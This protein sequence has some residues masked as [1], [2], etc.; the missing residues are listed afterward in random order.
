MSACGL[1]CESRLDALQRIFEHEMVHL[2]ERLC[3]GDSD[4][5]APRF[6]GIAARLFLHRAHTH[7]LITRRERAAESG[8][9]V[10]SRVSFTFEGRELTGRV[11]RVTQR[12]TVLVEDAAGEEYS[13]GLRYTRYYVPIARLKIV[14]AHAAG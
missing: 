7:S 11:N 3:W 1:E 5:A 10:G 12:V 2:V 6:Q 4:C 9:R 13:D 8:I 14:A